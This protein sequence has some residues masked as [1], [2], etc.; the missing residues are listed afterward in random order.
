MEIESWL[1]EK[2][3]D[4]SDESVPSL[5]PGDIVS[6][7]TIR[8]H[9]DTGGTA[10]VYRV[11]RDGIEAALKIAREIEQPRVDDRFAREADLLCALADPAFPKFITQG[12][13]AGRSFLVT[14]LLQPLELP[15]KDGAVAALVVRLA[16]AL[17]RLHALG[18]VHRDVKPANVLTR[19]GTTPVLVDLGYARPFTASDVSD[20]AS[21]LS[22]ERS[23]V[24]GLGTPGYAAPEQFSGLAV[25]PATDIHALGVLLDDC[26][27]G[28][29]PQVWQPLVRRATSSLPAQRYESMA[30]FARAV[31]RRHLRRSL[32][33][34][35]F[36]V[37]SLPA[38][39]SLALIFLSRTA[40]RQSRA[41]VAE[42]EAKRMAEQMAHD[43]AEAARRYDVVRRTFRDLICARDPVK[44][45]GGYNLG[46]SVGTNGCEV[47]N[48]T[49]RT[50]SK[51]VELDVAADGF[52]HAVLFL[53][54]VGRIQTIRLYYHGVG[55]SRGMYD[56]MLDLAWAKYASEEKV[57]RPD[58][59]ETRTF[60]CTRGDG[61][62]LRMCYSR[63]ADFPD[64]VWMDI[65]RPA[66]DAAGTA[67]QGLAK[68]LEQ[69]KTYNTGLD[70]AD[71]SATGEAKTNL[72][73]ALGGDEKG[74]FLV[75]TNYAM[76][77]GVKAD[78]D[79]AEYWFR[80]AWNGGSSWG[81][82]E[83][84]R[85]YLNHPESRS[86][87]VAV[88]LLEA[89]SANEDFGFYGRCALWDLACCHR[90]GIGTPKDEGKAAACW[91]RLLSVFPP[92]RETVTS[93]KLQRY[94][95]DAKAALDA[96]GRLPPIQGC[97]GG[98]LDDE[99][100]LAQF[101]RVDD[102][103]SADDPA[104]VGKVKEILENV[105]S[106]KLRTRHD[107]C[108]LGFEYLEGWRIARDPVRAE[109]W[110]RR[111]W[112]DGDVF[113]ILK[114]AET[115]LDGTLGVRS[116]ETA[117]RIFRVL[118]EKPR[119]GYVQRYA[120][121]ELGRCYQYGIGTAQDPEKAR[122]A[123]ARALHGY[124]ASPK[125]PTARAYRAAAEY[126]LKILGR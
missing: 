62:V 52:G 121:C 84:A 2:G 76:G 114:L 15:S 90:D 27:N 23:R 77:L 108:W 48:N 110:F 20:G 79:R 7:W 26:F 5:A 6:G 47:L 12:F 126:G 88:R 34:A 67:K 78:V 65:S 14:E 38:A 3:A 39:V 29:P 64:E 117:F 71:P 45:Y 63:R 66:Q 96:M 13:H 97:I 1:R 73:K 41:E 32:V 17:G 119:Y 28:H 70:P 74:M 116:P 8:A 125:S 31:R 25:T 118:S 72:E 22:V 112:M 93:H 109:Y 50:Y 21:R 120:L 83:L 89:L 124:D 104:A 35:S 113:G 94:R 100:F 122:G 24:V 111:A 69:F 33:F 103:V 86:V 43:E 99:D 9:L 10:E 55:R 82:Y 57:V 44:G 37:L 46:D 102:K 60:A 105:R 92:G 11:E 85:L 16:D 98:D 56:I 106:G 51:Q 54:P 107:L 91:W 81:L 36:A 59:G 95:A 75:A 115:Y 30:V 49:G 101:K 53:D 4:C 42:A 19:D 80:R 40:E 58:G 87:T 68:L 123:Y 61:V 18:Y